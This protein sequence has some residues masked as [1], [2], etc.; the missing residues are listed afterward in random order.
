VSAPQVPVFRI[1]FLNATIVSGLYLLAAAIIDV[2]RRVWSPRWSERASFAM[3]AFPAHT[4]DTMGL[5]S[6]LRQAALD[7]TVSPFM[8]RV[9]YGLVTV[10]LIFALGL[11]VAC[12]MWVVTKISGRTTTGRDEQ[13]PDA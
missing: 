13:P 2:V 8:V 9:I 6:P 1:S 5:L 7:G 4:L 10:G 3:E 12:G 11:V